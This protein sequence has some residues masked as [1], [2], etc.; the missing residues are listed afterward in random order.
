MKN[1]PK[2][3]R[4]VSFRIPDETYDRLNALCISKGMDMSLVV[5]EIIDR[6]L[7]APDTA[8]EDGQMNET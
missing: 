1:K 2:L 8:G 4:L 7:H 6:A 3:T 5:R